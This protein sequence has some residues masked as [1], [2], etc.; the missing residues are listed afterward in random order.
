MASS[1]ARSVSRAHAS[2]SAGKTTPGG[3]SFSEYRKPLNRSET[4]RPFT[5]SA[6]K[7]AH[8]PKVALV[9]PAYPAMFHTAGARLSSLVIGSLR[10]VAGEKR[11]KSRMRCSSGET[12]VIMLVQTMGESG[13]WIVSSAP[14]APS[15]TSRASCGMAPFAMYG[16]RICQSPPSSPTKITGRPSRACP[17]IA[18][19]A[20]RPARAADCAPLAAP[21]G[22]GEQGPEDPEGGEQQDVRLRSGH[23]LRSAGAASLTGGPRKRKGPRRSG[24]P[25]VTTS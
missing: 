12:P 8:R 16:S 14:P 1:T 9:R 6:G 13:G 2:R 15:A 23:V 7:V 10:P 5:R 17:S 11:V 22:E 25:P 21:P 18:G 4:R 3:G 24:A 19:M 20:P